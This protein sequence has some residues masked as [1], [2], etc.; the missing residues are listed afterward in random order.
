M[1]PLT[2][3]TTGWTTS[4]STTLAAKVK[5]NAV[6]TIV[7]TSYG[8]RKNVIT[9]P[10]HGYKSLTTDTRGF[11]GNRNVTVTPIHGYDNAGI[12]NVSKEYSQNA[13]RPTYSTTKAVYHQSKGTSV[14]SPSSY[15]SLRHQN[16]TPVAGYDNTRNTT[17]STTTTSLTSGSVARSDPN[18]QQRNQIVQKQYSGEYDNFDK[19]GCVTRYFQEANTGVQICCGQS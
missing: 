11:H 8:D 18:R 4:T 6:P 7:T 3:A 2:I 13:S 12:V 19:K 1:Q 16:A 10:Q 15:R 5:K 9:T 14:S 17:E